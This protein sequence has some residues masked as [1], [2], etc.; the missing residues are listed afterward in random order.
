MF[1]NTQLPPT[2]S[3]KAPGCLTP[4]ASLSRLSL[5][6]TPVR[7]SMCCCARL[8]IHTPKRAHR[9]PIRCCS[10]LPRRSTGKLHHPFMRLLLCMLLC[11]HVI[12]VRMR[13]TIRYVLKHLH[14]AHTTLIK[15]AFMSTHHAA[16]LAH[17]ASESLEHRHTC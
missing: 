10:C 14:Q 3:D 11:K 4:F 7:F 1:L 6:S 17:S 2:R 9:W 5:N 15:I 8:R 16:A 13:I 12:D